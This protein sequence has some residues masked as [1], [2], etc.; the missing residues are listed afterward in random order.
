MTEL[1]ILIFFVVCILIMWSEFRRPGGIYQYP[2]LA[3]ATFIGFVGIQIFGLN[4]NP[5]IQNGILNRITILAIMS[6]L[7]IFWGSRAG[8]APFKSFNYVYSVSRL[9]KASLIFSFIGAL[10]YFLISRLPEEIRMAS[11]PSGI[12]VAFRFFAQIMTYGFA[13][14]L[15]LYFSNNSKFALLIILFDIVIYL[16]RI[17]IAARRGEAALIIIMFFLALWF[18]KR[19]I[20]PKYFVVIGILFSTIFIYSTGDYRESKADQFSN[21][22]V[23]EINYQDN[24]IKVIDF[25]GPELEL[26]SYQIEAI[27]RRSDY[28]FGAFYWNSIVFNFI[29]A[30]IFGQNLKNKLTLKSDDAAFKE[31]GYEGMTG[32]TSTGLVDI[33]KSFWYFGVIIFYV[34]SY[35]LARIYSAAINGNIFMQLMYMIML[36][37]GIHSI[38]HNA[39]WFIS[40][41]IHMLLF[42]VPAL[43]Y[44]RRK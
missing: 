16:D 39:G 34:I 4:N 23:F 22:S 13:L 24:L 3:M 37:N 42:L 27:A 10:F 12:L 30:Q 18:V 15:I 20:V 25:G 14:A 40:P 41:F 11:Q 5:N 32:S 2:F 21:S 33:F 19:W 31:F 29:P 44:A 17:L 35:V 26:A 38:T 7:M 1:L 36:V 8:L 28:D 6:S 9:K 43:F